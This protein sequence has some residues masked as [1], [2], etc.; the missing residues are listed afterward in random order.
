M[1]KVH[2]FAA[3]AASPVRTC[4][5]LAAEAVLAG[6]PKTDRPCH[7]FTLVELLV[8]IAI[9]GT[10]VA[11]LL[12]AVQAAREAARRIQC[13]NNLKQIGLGLL[14]YHDVKEEFP[15]G[16]VDW[17]PPGKS[18][19]RQLAWS[20]YILPYVE[21]GA[22]FNQLDL[23][24]P[25]DDPTNELGASRVLQ[26]YLCP[27]SEI[28]ES[29][30]GPTHFAGINGENIDGIDRD[31][32][33]VRND[34]QKGV[35]LVHVAN[36]TPE[37]QPISIPEITD[38]TS[39]TLFVAEDSRF[40]DGQWINGRNVLSQGYAINS[41]EADPARENDI[42]SEHPGGANGLTCSGSVHFLSENMDLEILAALCSRAGGET[43]GGMP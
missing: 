33:L 32:S 10:L 5:Q 6:L 14:G 42:R 21:Q 2:L 22:L 38:G 11:L 31:N 9:I 19:N 35:L 3:I 17:R 34:P 1:R 30:F 36:F 27:S 23:S 8:V 16:C 15:I 7:G 12:P 41:P 20:A 43:V 25:F 24:K 13:Q 28:L 26:I 37:I 39:S 40:A 29:D 18:E 4:R